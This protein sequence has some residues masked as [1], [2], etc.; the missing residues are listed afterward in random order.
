MYHLHNTQKNAICGYRLQEEVLA[1]CC[2]V[3]EEDMPRYND[4][5][6]IP[7][8][9]PVWQ[10]FKKNGFDF[11]KFMTEK[12]YELIEDEDVRVEVLMGVCFPI[13]NL[14]IAHFMI[15]WL[16]GYLDFFNRETEEIT[17]TEV[18]HQLF[19][20]S[21][22]EDIWK[23]LAKGIGKIEHLYRWYMG[24][25]DT[26]IE[27]ATGIPCYFEKDEKKG[28]EYLDYLLDESTNARDGVREEAMRLK[29]I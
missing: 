25:P 26:A 8:Y 2:G 1:F 22:E 24:M 3:Q 29:S 16:N 11:Y 15:D 23:L 13:L 4:D 18:L 28:A 9:L 7:E 19:F 21:T 27:E 12:D 6:I 5:S 10:A 20:C 14:P 17:D